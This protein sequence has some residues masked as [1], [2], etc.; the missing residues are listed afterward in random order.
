MALYLIETAV[1]VGTG[2]FILAM[3][4]AGLAKYLRRSVATHA[5]QSESSRRERGAGSAAAS[6]S[7]GAVG[8]GCGVST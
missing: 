7:S 8:A 3:F 1:A 6:R 5:R 2:V 4:L